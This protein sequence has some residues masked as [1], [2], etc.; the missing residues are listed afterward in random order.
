MA[1]MV[2]SD[3]IEDVEPE[4]TGEIIRKRIKNKEKSD[5]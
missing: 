4:K 5:I 1:L 2:L 3:L